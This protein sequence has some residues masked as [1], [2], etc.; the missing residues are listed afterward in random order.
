M[1]LGFSGLQLTWCNDQ[2]GGAQASEC[3]D[4]VAMVSWLQ[5]ISSY[6]VHHLSRISFDHSPI[7]VSTII[8]CSSNHPSSLENFG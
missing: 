3:V 6:Q 1:N 7:I 4:S 2:Q 8:D 5:H